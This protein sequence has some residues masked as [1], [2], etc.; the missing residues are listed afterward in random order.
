MSHIPPLDPNVAAKKGF[1]ESEERLKRF[2]KTA[3]VEQVEGGW[4]VVL[5]GRSFRSFA[6]HG[7]DECHAWV[8][9]GMSKGFAI[10]GLRIGAVIAPNRKAADT[11]ITTQGFAQTIEGVATT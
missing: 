1:R 5:D 8:I 4:R 10:A 6:A 2:W 9:H 3:G 7:E 11:F